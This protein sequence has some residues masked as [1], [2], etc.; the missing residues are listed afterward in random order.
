VAKLIY[1]MMMSLADATSA[2]AA[3]E[4]SA[5]PDLLLRLHT[6]SDDPPRISAEEVLEVRAGPPA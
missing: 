2:V 3:A 5:D 6:T 1:G 4:V